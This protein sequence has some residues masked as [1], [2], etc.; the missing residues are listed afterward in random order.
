MRTVTNVGYDM[1]VLECLE[2]IPLK[3]F[4]IFEKVIFLLSY[5]DF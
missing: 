1:S 3:D 5:L 2:D 4:A